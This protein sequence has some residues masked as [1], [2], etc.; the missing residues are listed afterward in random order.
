MRNQNFD[1]LQWIEYVITESFGKESNNEALLAVP[2]IQGL[3][4][5]FKI[6][7]DELVVLSLLIDGG[8]RQEEQACRG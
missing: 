4:S 7:I 8:I 2:E 3:L 6:G 1:K 5:F